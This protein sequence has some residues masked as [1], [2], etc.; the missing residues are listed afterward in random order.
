MRRSIFRSAVGAAVTAVALLV[1]AP[2]AAAAPTLH[3]TPTGDVTVGEV[4]TVAVDGLPSNLAQ[5]AVGQCK[6]QVVAPTDCNLGASLLGSADAQGA[7][8]PGMRGNTITLTASVGAVDCTSAPGACTL[9]VTSL[10]DPG[11]ILASV[12]LTFTHAPAVA[13]TAPK[14]AAA[15]SDSSDSHTTA[16]VVAIV[17]VVVVVLAVAG[18]LVRRRR[19]T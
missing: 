1:T 13:T 18:L 17:V 16:I 3:P 11:N 8:Q 4:V 2:L 15:D 9:A 14:A 5:V 19:R 7:W 10:T 6:P 12:P